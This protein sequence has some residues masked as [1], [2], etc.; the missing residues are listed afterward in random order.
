[1]VGRVG[2]PAEG[3]PLSA[4]G[5]FGV[6]TH[7][8]SGE[9][10]PLT[11]LRHA[12]LREAYDYWC[13]KRGGGRAMPS[14][15]DIA[16]E[17][18]KSYLPRVMLIDVRRE[19]LDFVYRV[20]GSVIARAHG[21]EY[22]GKSARELEP[23]GFADLIWRQYLEVVDAKAPRL[24]A[25]QLESGGKYMNY[26]RLTL[27]LSSDGETVDKLLAVSIEDG[28]FWKPVTRTAE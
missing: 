13:G 5:F 20:F 26:Q 19:P 27:P 15:Q 7:K 21:R 14:R 11:E 2:P 17:E 18:M 12:V 28:S 22:T 16:P 3:V 23:A 9:S 8:F 1:L 25:I 24:H 6:E 10:L 4:P